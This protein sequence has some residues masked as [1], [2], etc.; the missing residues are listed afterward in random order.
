MIAFPFGGEKVRIEAPLPARFAAAL[1][2]AGLPLLL[3]LTAV[4][5]TLGLLGPVS[6]LLPVDDAISSVVLLVG[7]AV[8][9]AGTVLG[10]KDGPALEEGGEG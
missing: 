6:Q 8:G 9:V 5:G 1:V 10:S 4:M 7:L 3:A 2:A